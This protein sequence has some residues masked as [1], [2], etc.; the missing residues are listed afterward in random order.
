MKD[1][2]EN[3]QKRFYQKSKKITKALNLISFS[4]DGMD[5][6]EKQLEFQFDK[7]ILILKSFQRDWDQISQL[8]NQIGILLVMS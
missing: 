2:F 3:Y 8:C 4:S 1:L 6:D 5:I 7:N